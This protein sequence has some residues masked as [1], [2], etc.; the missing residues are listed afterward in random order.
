M[1]AFAAVVV[2]GVFYWLWTGCFS[3]L[4]VFSLDELP[5]VYNVGVLDTERSSGI[6]M[7]EKRSSPWVDKRFGPF[8]LGADANHFYVGWGKKRFSILKSGG[9]GVLTAPLM[10]VLRQLLPRSTLKYQAFAVGLF[11]E[12]LLL[13]GAF[14]F[15]AS[16]FVL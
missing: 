10:N 2:L 11:V 6:P 8:L 13:L 3:D 16:I 1:A 14:L 12:F 9:Y 15:F 5:P 4:L 7:V